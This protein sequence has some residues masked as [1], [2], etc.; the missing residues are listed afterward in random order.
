VRSFLSRARTP[1]W[2]AVGDPV[3]FPK[4]RKG[5]EENM[6]AQ[7]QEL[8]HRARRAADEARAG[9]PRGALPASRAQGDETA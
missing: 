4:E 2:A 8:V 5:L 7:V 6:R 9:T 1:V 3:P